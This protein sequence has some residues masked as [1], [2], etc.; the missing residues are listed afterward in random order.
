MFSPLLFKVLLAISNIPTHAWSMEMTQ[1]II[2]SSC[3]VFEVSPASLD[4]SD[5]SRF[6][7]VAWSLHPDLIPNEVGCIFP[8]PEDPSVVGEPPL[9]HVLQ[10]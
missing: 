2:D 10:S 3:L 6:F 4:R 8:E 9:F 7:A 5:M 1:H